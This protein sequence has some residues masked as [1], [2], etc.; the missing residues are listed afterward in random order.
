MAKPY[1][2]ANQKLCYIQML[3]N[4]ENSLGHVK[5]HSEEW[6]VNTDP[7]S[8]TAAILKNIQCRFIQDFVKIESNMTFDWLNRLV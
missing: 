7:G 6:L 1:G 2:L 4:I 8:V 5:E 3:Q